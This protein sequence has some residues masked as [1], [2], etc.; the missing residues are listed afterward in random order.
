MTFTYKTTD[1]FK[2]AISPIS[3][4]IAIK[5]TLKKTMETVLNKGHTINGF[6]V[7]IFGFS[8]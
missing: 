3:I 6:T 8:T 5:Y 7:S 4:G 1:I 2:K